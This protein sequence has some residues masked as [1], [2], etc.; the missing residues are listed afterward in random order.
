[1]AGA[2]SK[3]FPSVRGKS[4]HAILTR[5]ETANGTGTPALAGRPATLVC[6]LKSAFRNV[7]RIAQSSVLGRRFME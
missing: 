3:D 6:R 5:I 4:L 2:A 1:M 7:S